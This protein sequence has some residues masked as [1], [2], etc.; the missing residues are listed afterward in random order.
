ME[1]GAGDETTLIGALVALVSVTVT[2]LVAMQH[3]KHTYNI[4]KTSTRALKHFVGDSTSYKMHMQ[5]TIVGF[6]FQHASNQLHRAIK[7]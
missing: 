7:C 4:I 5:F 2:Q 3:Q 6:E 1:K